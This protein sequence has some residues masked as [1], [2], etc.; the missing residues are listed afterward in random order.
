M[1]VSCL[2][3][4][5][6]VECV[7]AGPKPTCFT[8]RY[9]NLGKL[10]HLWSSLVCRLHVKWLNEQIICLDHNVWLLFFPLLLICC[11]EFLMYQEISIQYYLE[12]SQSQ[13]KVEFMI[14]ILENANWLWKQIVFPSYITK[15]VMMKSEFYSE[16]LFS[17]WQL[18]SP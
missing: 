14:L 5:Q 8:T 6:I 4:I 7:K 12:C 17:P 1:C 10:L 2:M 3:A 11:S 9:P 15:I 18:A 13:D 16:L